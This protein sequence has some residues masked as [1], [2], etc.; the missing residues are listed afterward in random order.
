[1]SRMSRLCLP[2]L[3]SPSSPSAVTQAKGSML[4]ASRF[5]T[6]EDCLREWRKGKGDGREE[7][8]FLGRFCPLSSPAPLPVL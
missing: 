1:M 2:P 3:S 7:A 5:L 8:H 4:I 6:S